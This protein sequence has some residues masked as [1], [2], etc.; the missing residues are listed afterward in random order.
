MARG[1]FVFGVLSIAGT[2]ALAQETPKPEV[3]TP[4]QEVATK[5]ATPTFSSKVNLVM[6]PVVVRDKSGHAVGTL[7]KEDFLLFDRGKPQTITRFQIEKE[8]DRIKP[9]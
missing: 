8:A 6:V 2:A 4:T 1:I 7:K 5:E 3:A 9:V